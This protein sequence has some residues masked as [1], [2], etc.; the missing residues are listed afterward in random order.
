MKDSQKAK[1][2]AV[3]GLKEI[4]FVT[5]GIAADTS[6]HVVSE[7][8]MTRIAEALEASDTAVATATA[9]VQ[10]QLDVANAA[11]VKAETELA[12]AKKTITEKETEITTLNTKVE[13]LEN[14][15]SVTQTT[16]EADKNPKKT[17]GYNADADP[18]N[19]LADSILGVSISKKKE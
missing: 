13:E 17:K 4:P 11:K 18:I 6:G 10:S 7:D 12:A 2:K 5:E 19:M 15:G 16:K 1:L 14:D 9:T 3:T 8:G